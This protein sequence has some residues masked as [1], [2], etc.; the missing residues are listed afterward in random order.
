MPGGIVANAGSPSVGLSQLGARDVKTCICGL[1]TSRSS[2][3]D[4]RKNVIP[5]LA[6]LTE[7]TGAPQVGQKCRVTTLPLSAGRA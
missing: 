5:G 6:E 3:L 7:N 2:R 4:A 1:K